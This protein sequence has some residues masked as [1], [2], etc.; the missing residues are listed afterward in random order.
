MHAYIEQPACRIELNEDGRPSLLA[1]FE[2]T[3]EFS[4]CAEDLADK[5]AH[6]P[7]QPAAIPGDLGAGFVDTWCVT[8]FAKT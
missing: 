5:L 8:G 1:E 3:T 4:P 7:S 6:S 2:R